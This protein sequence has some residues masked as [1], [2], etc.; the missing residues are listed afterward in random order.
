LLPTPS[1][2]IET[3][4]YLEKQYP[5]NKFS[6]ILGADNMENFYKW[7]N[8][9]DILDRYLIYVYPRNAENYE[10]TVNHPHVVY[11]NAPL[12][13][14]SATEIREL[15][16]QKKTVDE[17]LPTEVLRYIKNNHIF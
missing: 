3:L 7:K 11:L 8:Y 1:Y 14:V 6:L 9:E 16:K 2:T 12:L 10:K 5:N 13:S 17:Y 4:Y 15:L